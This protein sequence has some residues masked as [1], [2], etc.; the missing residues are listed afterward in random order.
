MTHSR[1][2][3]RIAL[4]AFVGLALPTLPARAQIDRK[5]LPS[6]YHV[7]SG[8][9]LDLKYRATPEYDQTV[10]VLPDGAV[11]L[12]LLGNVQMAGLTLPEIHD[13]LVKLASI[14]LKDPELSV[15]VKEGL[16]N[17][18]SV[19]GEV[20]QPGRFELHGNTTALEALSMAGGFK[21]TSA[22]KSVILVRKVDNSSTY[23]EA[24][25]LNFKQLKKVSATT[26]MPILR[27]GDVL[28]ISGDRLSKVERFLKL[29]NAGL[30]IPL[31]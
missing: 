30:Y 10:T 3:T 14:R 21:T 18:F 15:S 22:E 4:L 11:N 6:G 7:Q 31:P 23:G 1:R 27:P 8:D 16:K 20:M 17:H 12:E 26:E 13:E 2:Q 5:L 29:A 28:I 9:V 19:I 24:I 25:R